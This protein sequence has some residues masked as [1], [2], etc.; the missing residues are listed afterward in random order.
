LVA[1]KDPTVTKE[2]K[3]QASAKLAEI[4]ATYKTGKA[5]AYSALGKTPG[6]KD[7]KNIPQLAIY[8][9]SQQPPDTKALLQEN[10]EAMKS[11]LGE[12]ANLELQYAPKLAEV[13]GKS[14]REQMIKNIQA[15]T[16]DSAS[17]NVVPLAGGA[18]GTAILSA[19]AGRWAT[20]VSDGTNWVV[21]NGVI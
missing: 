5:T 18:A 13:T 4:N 9:K 16:V 21:M 17:S 15:Q 19:N 7:A 14:Q 2:L 3:E 20:L 6:A 1:S 12:A 8:A 11:V 10:V